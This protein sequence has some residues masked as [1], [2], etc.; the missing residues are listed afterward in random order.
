MD[1]LLYNKKINLDYEV[2]QKMTAGIELEGPEVKSLRQKH[3]N[4]QGAYVTIR[5]GEAYLI[6]CYIPPYQEKNVPKEY[7]PYQNRRLLLTKAE[8][9]ALTAIE[10][11]KGLTIVPIAMYNNKRKIKAEIGIVR[12]KKKYDKRQDLKKHQA[13]RDMRR[14]M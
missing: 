1:Q 5:G 11:Q 4:L 10:R 7:D 12:G 9:L 3:G 8:I 14:E 13:E 6:N 2:L